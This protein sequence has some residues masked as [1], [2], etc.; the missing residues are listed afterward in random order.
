MRLP[1]SL[2]ITKFKRG[3]GGRGTW[4]RKI[5]DGLDVQKGVVFLKPE[6]VCF[7]I[8]FSLQSEVSFG[9]DSCGIRE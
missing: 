8:G 6:L 5:Q 1:K 7:I 4:R 2:W 9:G 3:A